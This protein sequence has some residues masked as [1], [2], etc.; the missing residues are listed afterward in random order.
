[1]QKTYVDDWKVYAVIAESDV[2]GLLGWPFPCYCV[3]AT[4]AAQWSDCLDE[5]TKSAFRIC[6]IYPRGGALY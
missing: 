5:P 3:P 1:M 2:W 6:Q 4:I